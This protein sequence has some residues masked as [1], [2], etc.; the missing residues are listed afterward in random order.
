MT[1]P[2][3]LDLNRS[4]I[5]LH[6]QFC[7]CQVLQVAPSTSKTKMIECIRHKLDVEFKVQL[8]KLP[9]D[10]PNPVRSEQHKHTVAVLHIQFCDWSVPGGSWMAGW[11]SL[12]P[13]VWSQFAIVLSQ[14][15][16]TIHLHWMTVFC[17]V[18]NAVA[19]LEYLNAPG[20]CDCAFAWLHSSRCIR[21]SGSDDLE[22][23]LV[24]SVSKRE[25]TQLRRMTALLLGQPPTQI[26]PRYFFSPRQC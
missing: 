14:N 26:N 20:T 15:Q 17:S 18:L 16:Q 4:N 7:N 25:L 21:L 19:L 5:L 2:P 3:Q 23:K 1:A 22:E 10:S 24:N 8:Y 11:V 12:P 13:T 9:V 6:I